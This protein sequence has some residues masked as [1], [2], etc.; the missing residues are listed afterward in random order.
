MKIGLKKKSNEDPIS[1]QAKNFIE[2]LLRKDP[3]E[4]IY[5][6][7]IL[8]HAFFK[9]YDYDLIKNKKLQSPLK[10][11]IEEN[12]ED[13]EAFMDKINSKNN[14]IKI[15]NKKKRKSTIDLIDNGN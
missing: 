4:R 14:L 3:D 8:K 9:D 6:S 12:K 13:L 2:L 5:P 7:E 1:E 15:T 11:L 10:R